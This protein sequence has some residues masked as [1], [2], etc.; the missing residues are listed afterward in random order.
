M[1]D[2]NDT[3]ELKKACYKGLKLRVTGV[4]CERISLERIDQ[5]GGKWRMYVNVSEVC[6]IEANT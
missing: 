1:V 4:N 5:H 2:I 3:V 6:K